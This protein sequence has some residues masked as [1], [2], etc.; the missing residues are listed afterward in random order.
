MNNTQIT[1]ISQSIQAIEKAVTNLDNSIG[2]LVGL[3]TLDA[4]VINTDTSYTSGY[5]LVEED[6]VA[7]TEYYGYLKEEGYWIIK[8]IDKTVANIVTT[9]YIKGDDSFSTN[10]TNRAS[11]T[12]NYIDNI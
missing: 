11:L 12:Y 4:L 1:T 8:Q 6:T 2:G 10:W 3:L 5:T 9:K 7:S